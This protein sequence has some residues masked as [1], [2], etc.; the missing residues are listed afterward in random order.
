MADTLGL[1]F[2]GAWNDPNWI[3]ISDPIGHPGTI[4]A[5]TGNDLNVDLSPAER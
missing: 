1:V 2:Y 5:G 4:P 3:D